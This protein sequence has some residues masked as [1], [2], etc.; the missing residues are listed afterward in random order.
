MSTYT[1]EQLIAFGRETTTPNY[2]PAPIVIDRGEG[3]RVWDSEGREYLDF[4]A[5]IAVCSVGH[6]HPKLVEAIRDQAGKILQISNAFFSE[7]QVLLQRELTRRTFAD[8]VYFSNS[9]AEAVEAALKLTRRYQRVVR[10]S[11][12]FEFITFERSFHGRTFGAITATGQPK[13]HAGFEPLV[14]GFVYAEFDNLASVEALVSAHTAGIVVEPVQGEGGV[15]AASPE[16]LRGLR[17]LC[18]REGIVLIFDEVQ[19]GM[20]R[21]GRLYAHEHYGVTPDVMASAKGIAGGVPL[22]AMLCTEELSRGFVRGSHASTYGGNPLATRA[23]LTVLS[24]LDEENLL[25]KATAVGEYLRR[26]ALE[27][28]SRHPVIQ[29]VRGLGAMN[30]IVLEA[31]ASAASSVVQRARSRGLLLNTAG[32]NVLRLVP[33]LTVGESD[34]D[35]AMGIL[36]GCLADEF[37]S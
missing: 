7:P 28:A 1:T 17:E 6:S 14:P 20:G 3:A 21:T 34:V 31:E 23:G 29:D 19:C 5:G 35:E 26:S 30:G 25:E 9:G 15:R 27:L 33:P 36:D 18:D 2:L 13:Y 12:R 11:P 32:G 4:L 24:I 16:F 37:G 10:E 22:G 8:R